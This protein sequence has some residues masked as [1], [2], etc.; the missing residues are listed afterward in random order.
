MKITVTYKGKFGQSHLVDADGL[1]LLVTD[2]SG[3]MDDRVEGEVFEMTV[4]EIKKN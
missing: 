2:F 4:K 3:E 1:E